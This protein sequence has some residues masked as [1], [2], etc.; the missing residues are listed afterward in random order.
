[1]NRIYHIFLFVL[2]A[3]GS[4]GVNA[5][6]PSYKTTADSLYA[7]G[8]YEQAAEIYEA[9]LKEGEAAE[10]Y[11]NLGNCYYKTEKLAYA[12]LNYE[13]AYRLNPADPDIEANLNFVRALTLDKVNPPSELFFVTWWKD[14]A[15][16]FSMSNWKT[17]AI[18]S[19]ILLLTGLLAYFFVSS[20]LIR[21]IGFYAAVVG[22]LFVVVSNLCAW[23][24]SQSLQQHDA[25]IITSPVST[26]YSSPNN[27]S[28]H[29][30]DIHEGTRVEIL[31]QSTE[32]WVEIFL[33]E[34][35]QG[36]ASTNDLE[37]I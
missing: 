32:E 14:L 31:D 3:F 16:A 15:N 9:L 27:T 28:T 36:W 18:V 23:T 11:Y 20:S 7:E 1:M 4:E 17:I 22:A 26:V 12:I 8:Q 19:F 37:I 34:G 5:A 29:L 35:K 24:Q 30:F 6:N 2:F 10:L 13:R 25:A 33:E 21:R